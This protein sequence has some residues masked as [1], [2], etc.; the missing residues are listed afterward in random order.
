MSKKDDKTVTI[1]LKYPFSLI[2]ERLAVVKI[3]PQAAASADAKAFDANPV[4]TGPYQMTD[5]GAA[6]KSIVFQRFDGYTGPRPALAK[7]MTWKI[8]PDAST[9]TNALQSKAVQAI[10]SVPYLSIDQ[11]KQSSTVDSVQGFG[12]LFAMFNCGSAPFNDVKNRQAVL[13]AID[14]DK[15]ISTALLGN[16]AA[17]SSFVPEN[18]P[19]YQKAATVYALDQDKAKSLLAQ[20][21]LTNMRML[22]TDHDWVQNVTPII[23]ENLE[24]SGSGVWSGPQSTPALASAGEGR[25]AHQPRLP[26][27]PGRARS[28]GRAHRP[29]APV[30]RGVPGA[31]CRA[32]AVPPMF[33]ELPRSVVPGLAR[34]T[35]QR[36]SCV[37][38]SGASRSTPGRRAMTWPSSTPRDPG[39]PSAVVPQPTLPIRWPARW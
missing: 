37:H 8:V 9:R 10:D 1:A 3:V 27:R 15:V 13:Y 20:T 36:L 6:S 12:L 4:G 31:E 33:A 16:A 19:A 25:R 24:G 21:G 34:S 2:N 26:T 30:P 22:C 38:G 5:N 18:N 17:A 23:K 35:A 39:V 11:L 28:W 7:T 29:G 32:P 14:M